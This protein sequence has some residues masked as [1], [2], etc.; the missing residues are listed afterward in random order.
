MIANNAFLNE[1]SER[2]NIPREPHEAEEQWYKRLAY[3]LVGG[4]MLASLYDFDDDYSS[5][6]LEKNKTVSMQHVLKRGEGL[7]S[8]LGI[9]DLDCAYLREL[10]TQT[11]YMLHKNNR[12][13]YP[14]QKTANDGDVSFIRGIVPWD[15]AFIGGIG[16]YT[17]N[18][19][20]KEISVGKMF[21]ITEQNID[22][23]F[24]DFIKRI[25]WQQTN[26][27]PHEAEF[28]N[29]DDKATNGYWQTK[30]PKYGMSLCRSNGIGQKEYSLV[31]ISD[32]TEKIVL[33][34]WQTENGE[35]LRIAI[36]L[37]I[38]KNNAPIATVILKKHIAEIEIDY[39]LPKAEQNFF[40]LYSWPN[41]GNNKWRRIIAIKIYPTFRHMLER[42]GY[43][44]NEV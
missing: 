21:G 28:L 5:E 34:E 36:A 43:E 35:Y 10:Y 22:K 15:N 16:L 11:G 39:L 18:T 8:T 40:E 3:S 44:I 27:L 13:V 2:L 30:V 4:H 9:D 38:E 12:L 23:W 24:S 26:N 7:T 33:P 17:E 42:L 29:I 32:K 1:V 25:S 20:I 37:R 14:P 41:I 19:G 31:R 6:A